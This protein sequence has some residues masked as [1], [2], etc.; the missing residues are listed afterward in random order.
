MNFKTLLLEAV[1]TSTPETLYKAIE[2]GQVPGVSLKKILSSEVSSRIGHDTKKELMSSLYY[3]TE[4]VQK[5]V[6]ENR[7]T[8]ISPIILLVLKRS[9]NNFKILSNL[10]KYFESIDPYLSYFLNKDKQEAKTAHKQ[11]FDDFVNSELNITKDRKFE[12]EANK[13]F[14]SKAQVKNY[15]K[16]VEVVYPEDGEGWEVVSPKTFAAASKLACYGNSKAN[17]CTSANEST[18]S[19]YS[20]NNNKLF[21]IRNN[22]TGTMFQMDFGEKYNENHYSYPNFKNKN[23]SPTTLN[24]LLEKN[25]SLEVF[26]SIKNKSGKSVYEILGND[27]FEYGN[28]VKEK[29]KSVKKTLAKPEE[30]EIKGAK[31]K[32]YKTIFLVKEE[33]PE[34]FKNGLNVDK[35]ISGGNE[36]KIKNKLPNGRIENYL[37]GNRAYLH[38]ELS[39]EPEIEIKENI[40]YVVLKDDKKYVYFE[41]VPSSYLVGKRRTR[42]LFSLYEF[43]GSGIKNHIPQN[44]VPEFLKK[45]INKKGFIQ[46][47]DFAEKLEKEKTDDFEKP[48]KISDK[49]NYTVNVQKINNKEQLFSY[50]ENL[51]PKTKEKIL[52][53]KSIRNIMYKLKYPLFLVLLR[54][55][56]AFYILEKNS[57]K[58]FIYKFY[59]SRLAEEK[60][61]EVY[62][63]FLVNIKKGSETR[64]IDFLK[65]N[66]PNVYQEYKRHIFKNLK[67]NNELYDNPKKAYETKKERYK[68]IINK[69]ID[70]VKEN[71]KEEE[72]KDFYYKKFNSSNIPEEIREYITII[73]KNEK[74]TSDNLISIT[75][76]DNPLYYY[77]NIAGEKYISTNAPE[78]NKILFVGEKKRR[79]T[80]L[81]EFV[82]INNSTS[83]SIFSHSTLVNKIRKISEAKGDK[84]AIRYDDELNVAFRDAM[85]SDYRKLYE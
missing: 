8:L 37:T 44:E 11:L 14:A 75:T 43:D 42:K 52:F 36:L 19:R 6:P 27:V 83:V 78:Y 61:E 67:N 5:D 41:G 68:K 9:N 35:K 82:K 54:G 34:I 60:K 71:I 64:F 46:R 47:V 30:K 31:V 51:S 65:E 15:G 81:F 73:E 39:K 76:T 77:F 63:T 50:I 62:D 16:E 66:L 59:Y 10:D 21:I 7:K 1:D 29:I 40:V 25:V 12:Q 17:W 23:D 72:K 55:G 32:K 74:P 48:I 4:K 69:T 38:K 84:K 49:G 45:T 26:K 85:N 3:L 18:F 33:Y 53:N 56:Y 28:K 22:K 2:R 70:K 13:I 20:A 24:K 57:S 79:Y 58:D 80:G